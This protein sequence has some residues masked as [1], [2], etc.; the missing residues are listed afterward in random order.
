MGKTTRRKFTPESKANVALEA[1]KESSTKDDLAKKYEIT[2]RLSRN[3]KKELMKNA[4]AAFGAKSDTDDFDKERHAI[5]RKNG[6]L[7]RDVGF[8]KRASSSWGYPYPKG[9]DISN[10]RDCRQGR[11]TSPVSEQSPPVQTAWDN[12]KHIL[13][14]AQGRRKPEKS[15]D[16]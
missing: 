1:L 15:E 9:T 5:Y 13:L 16:D 3:E 7:E 6:D 8:C 14:Q 11:K 10:G 2:H 12:Q 4:S